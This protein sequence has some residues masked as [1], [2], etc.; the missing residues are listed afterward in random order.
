MAAGE[1]RDVDTDPSSLSR[2]PLCWDQARV[3][4]DL[5]DLVSVTTA[6]KSPLVEGWRD[7]SETLV[8]GLH[9][10]SAWRRPP[11][12]TPPPPT[13]CLARHT[14]GPCRDCGPT[15]ASWRSAEL[16]VPTPVPAPG[17]V[18]RACTWTAANCVPSLTSCGRKS[19]M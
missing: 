4:W 10:C 12:V 17:G 15:L 13:P 5:A 11:R 18:G 2:S 14:R 16:P 3:V 7:I 9:V 8:A 6:T 19:A 1:D